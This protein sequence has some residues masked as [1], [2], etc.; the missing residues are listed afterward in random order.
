MRPRPQGRGMRRP[1]G[2]EKIP[3]VGIRHARRSGAARDRLMQVSRLVETA[4]GVEGGQN[5]EW[6]LVDLGDIIV[7]VM[8]PAVRS[9]YNLEELWGGKEVRLK[10][11]GKAVRRRA[12]R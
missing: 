8:L 12:R 7:H 3:Q 1:H 9:Y 11:R 2:G 6:V 4:Q 5:A 10:G